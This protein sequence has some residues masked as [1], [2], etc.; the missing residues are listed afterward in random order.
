MHTPDF[1]VDDATEL[2]SAPF[3]AA[4]GVELQA[5]A[6]LGPYVIRR[7]LGEGGMGRVYLAEQTR[8]VRRDVA[9]KLIREQV[10]GPLARAYFDVERQALAQMQHPAIAQVFDAGTTEDGHPYLVMEV[11]E[12]RPLNTFCRDGKIGLDER[13]S[14]FTRICRGV[15]HAHQ[16]GIIHRDL[17]PA[18]V[19]VRRVDGEAMPK[20]ID[21]GIAIGNGGDNTEV[22]TQSTERAGTAIYMSPEQSGN[23]H[24]D[25]DT[26]SDVYSLGVMLYEVLTGADAAALTPHAHRSNLAPHRTLLA[27]IDS[28]DASTPTSAAML[29][30][31]RRLPAELRAILRKALAAERADRYDSAAALADDIERYQEKR[32]VKAMPQ[33][34][35][36]LARTFVSRHRLGLAAATFAFVALAIGTALALDGLVRARHAAERAQLEANKATQIAEF[37]QQMLSG[38]DPDRARSMDRSLLRMVLNAAADRAEHELGAQPAVRAEIEHTI[39]NSYASLGELEP[40]GK[41]YQAAIDAMR[42]AGLPDAKLARVV[43]RN[44]E[45]IDNQGNPQEAL[46]RG[47]EALALVSRQPPEDRDRLHVESHFAGLEC[48]AGL[49]DESRLRYEHALGLQRRL[50]GETDSDTL[51]TIDGLANTTSQM[52]RYDESR[53]LYETLIAARRARYGEENSKTLGAINGLAIVELEQKHFARAEALLAPIVPVAERVLGADHGATILFISNLGGA[54]RQQGRNEEARPYYERVFDYSSKTYG[55][56]AVRTIIAESNLSLLL[57]DAGELP[58]ALAHA[59]SAAQHADETLGNNPMRALFHKEL[60]TILTRMQRW[61]EAERELSNA[62]STFTAAKD[63]GPAH[64]RAQEVVDAYV[65]LYRSWKKPDLQARWEARRI[66]AQAEPIAAGMP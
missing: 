1:P 31:A 62:W 17:K 32:P 10:A 23:R 51:D 64:P 42:A 8:P 59:R 35:L 28:D 43:I 6:Q 46:E 27:A 60:A 19:L 25:I 47:R 20:I 7:L 65:D 37:V 66:P 48:D 12:G 52:A 45:N 41:H 9:L 26:R 3:E 44:A 53:R 5:G 36:Y 49:L 40:A 54:I 58:L 38:I 55:L 63:Y 33:T 4:S 50:F 34:R 14:L 56:A 21:F 15:Q 57:R 13:L 2:Q 39:A 24:R 29:Q 22:S 11:V 61:P 18:N 30:A 16:K